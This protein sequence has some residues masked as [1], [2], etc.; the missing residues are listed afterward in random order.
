ML[1]G[2]GTALSTQI[3]LAGS[4]L[5]A[6]DD[7]GRLG[8]IEQQIRTMQRQHDQEMRALQEELRHVRQDLAARDAQV[9]AAQ[10]Q[11][12]RAQ[13]EAQAA[14]AQAQAGAQLRVPPGAVSP[15]AQNAPFPGTA[16]A[17]VYGNGLTGQYQ[18]LTGQGEAAQRSLNAAEGQPTQ[19][20]R[21]GVPGNGIIQQPSLVPPNLQNVPQGINVPGTVQQEQAAAVGTSNSTFQLGGV[22]VT[23]GGFV[24]LSSLYRSRNEVADEFS[25]WNTAIPFPQSQLNHEGEFRETARASRLSLLVQGKP[26]PSETLG[27]Y[28]EVDFLGTGPSSNSNEVNRYNAGIRQAYGTYDNTNWGF[29]VLAGQSW[30]LLTQNQI[31]IIPRQENI[32]LTPDGGLVPGFTYLRGP[33]LRVVKDFAD[34]RIW[35]GASLESPQ[36]LYSFPA[37]NGLTSGSVPLAPIGTINYQNPGVIALPPNVNYS[38]EIAPDVIVKAAFDPGWGHYEILGLARFMHDRV[39]GVGDGHNNTVLAGGG[40]GSVLLPLIP[41]KLTFQ[42]NVLGGY[43]IGRY[44]PGQLP[45]ATIGTGGQPVP[46]PEIGALAGLVAHPTT[47]LDLYA[48]VGTEQIGRSSFNLGTNHYGYGNPLFSNAGCTIELST[49]P[50]AGN[51]SGI[52]QGA[53]GA[54]WRFFKG[55]YGTAQVGAEYS[56]T[57]RKLFTSVVGGGP[58]TDENIFF[59]TLRYLP[60]Q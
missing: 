26:S 60:F 36:T 41:K 29:H 58:S 39:S 37:V 44:L 40:G 7:N 49:L 47:P 32:P 11:A 52:V 9:K 13:S 24:E 54:W 17:P 25:N 3:L 2:V 57:R 30:S 18:A 38:T 19:P 10:A 46:L 56:Y 15:A 14:Q 28:V 50:C 1:L 21:T 8:E 22:T 20:A 34:H 33:G 12:A 45:D 23:L 59:L 16:P 35:L 5:A 53:L 31:G 27:A 4:V 6:D 42:A 48:Y 51:T 43:G 55:S